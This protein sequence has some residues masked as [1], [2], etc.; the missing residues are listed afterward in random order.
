MIAAMF[1][2]GTPVT[3]PCDRTAPV[4]EVSNKGAAAVPVPKLIVELAPVVPLVDFHESSVTIIS[5]ST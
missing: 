4:A 2:A 1:V 5:T 3:A